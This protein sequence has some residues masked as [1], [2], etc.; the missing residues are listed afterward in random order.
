[1]SNRRE[2]LKDAGIMAGAASV[3]GYVSLPGSASLVGGSAAAAETTVDP[4]LPPSGVQAGP[5]PP[6]P[7]PKCTP[8]TLAARGQIVAKVDQRLLTKAERLF[9]GTAQGRITEMLQNSRRAGATT[10]WILYDED[11]KFV[12]YFDDGHGLTDFGQLLA[13]GFSGWNEGIEAAEDPAG[14]GFFSLAPRRVTVHSRGRKVVID[15]GGWLGMPIDVVPSDWYGKGIQME[16]HDEWDR[17]SVEAEMEYGPLT[18]YYNGRKL[19]N[20]P[21]ISRDREIVDCPELGC[22]IQLSSIHRASRGRVHYRDHYVNFNFH[23]QTLASRDISSP[24]Q[25]ALHMEVSVELTGAPTEL[26]MVLPAREKLM[27]NP[28]AKQLQQVIEKTIYASLEGKTHSLPYAIYKKGRELGFDLDEA[29][30]SWVE[31]VG[32]WH[33]HCLENIDV[34]SYAGSSRERIGCDDDD[35]RCVDLLSAYAPGFKFVPC[36]PSAGMSGYSWAQ[37]LVSVVRTEVHPTYYPDKE[38]R[39][40]V[41]GMTLQVCRTIAV[42]VETDED[43]V[44]PKVYET[45]AAFDDQKEVLYITK[46]GMH[47]ISDSAIFAMTGGNWDE[48][49]GRDSQYDD[50]EEEMDVI[51]ALLRGPYEAVRRD[52]AKTTKALAKRVLSDTGKRWDSARIDSDGTV[53]LYAKGRLIAKVA[54]PRDDEA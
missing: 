39:F 28:A 1:M 37:N 24:V 15:E 23:G 16:F 34:P 32:N 10:V 35:G 3:A 17:A 31:G 44:E 50:F 41:N 7:T 48:D 22:R 36:S 9:G 27:I 30:E 26:R 53:R 18:V 8:E 14:A 33:E 19:L 42:E 46:A 40:E 21:F 43:D 13:M 51:M 52:V 29:K 2:F 12:R 47:D 54:E 49:R 4:S 11:N 20:R 38:W 5:L 6:V 25:D 45:S